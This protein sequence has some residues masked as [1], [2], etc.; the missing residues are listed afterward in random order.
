MATLGAAGVNGAKLVERKG[1]VRRGELLANLPGPTVLAKK[2]APARIFHV[3]T[4]V[5]T[6]AMQTPGKWAIVA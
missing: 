4:T 5:F 3:S 1:L 6:P 2:F